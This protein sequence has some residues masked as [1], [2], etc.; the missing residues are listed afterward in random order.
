MA[1]Q[2]GP[3]EKFMD[4]LTLSW[5]FVEGSDDLFFKVPPLA[6]DALLTVLD[7]LHENIK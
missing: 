6:S 4:S 5:N 7:P 3:F 2:Q 1:E